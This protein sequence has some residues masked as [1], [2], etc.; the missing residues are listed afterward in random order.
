MKETYQWGKRRVGAR[1]SGESASRL[2]KGMVIVR[3][4]AGGHQ[5]ELIIQQSGIQ[6]D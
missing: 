3:A 6:G 2:Q 4:G 5:G 1:K